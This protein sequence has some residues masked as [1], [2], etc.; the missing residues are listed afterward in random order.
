MTTTAAADP[1]TD[2]DLPGHPGGS[3]VCFAAELWGRFSF[4]GVNYLLLHGPADP[5]TPALLRQKSP[6]GLNK[7]WTICLAGLAAVFVAAQVARLAA[8]PSVDVTVSDLASALASYTALFED[9][10]YAG[11]AVGVFMLVVAPL[12]KKMM[13]GIH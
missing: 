5:G 2:T 10:L 9:L 6:I 12:Q 7:E 8:I 11:L 13:H 3:Y 4:Y 1:T